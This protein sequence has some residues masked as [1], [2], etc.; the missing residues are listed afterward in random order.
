MK[1]VHFEQFRAI[2]GNAGALSDNLRGE[3]QVLEYPFV[4]IGQGAAAGPLLLDTGSAGWLAQHP[5]LCNK[6]DVAVGEF[7]FEFAGQPGRLFINR[8]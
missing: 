1:H 6:Y 3:N 7:L 2:Y 5:A 8:D 4:D